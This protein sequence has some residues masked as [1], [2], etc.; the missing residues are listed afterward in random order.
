[1]LGPFPWMN[2]SVRFSG[3]LVGKGGVF[4]KISDTDGGPL[5]G[6]FVALGLSMGKVT[7][8][9]IRDKPDPEPVGGAVYSVPLAGPAGLTS[10][11]VEFP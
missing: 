2:Q 7:S 3:K 8:E 11:V 4:S 5:G 6:C 10:C 1:V 9:F